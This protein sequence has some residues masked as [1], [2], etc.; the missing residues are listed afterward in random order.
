MAFVEVRKIQKIQKREEIM[1]TDAKMRNQDDVVQH[2]ERLRADFAALSDTVAKLASESASGARSQLREA[3]NSAARMTGDA[4]HQI[5]RDASVLGN[6][7]IDT[8]NAAVGQFE[9]QIAKNPLTAVLAA[10]GV[11][12]FLGLLSHRR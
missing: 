10:L 11:G 3:A 9:K 2:L 8:A 5:Y 7:A 6:D 1:A 4:G 12:F